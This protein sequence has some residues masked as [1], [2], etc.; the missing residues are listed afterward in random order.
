MKIK[1][2]FLMREVAGENVVIAVGEAAKSFKGMIRLNPTGAFLWKL[3]EK[4]TDEA[5]M[6]SA[7][8]D[9]YETDKETAEN[10]I[11]AFVG[12]IRAA[13]LLDE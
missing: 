1:K 13:G 9:A 5:A 10:D 12:S 3:L 2:G 6:L 8:L 4:D 11:R 7:M